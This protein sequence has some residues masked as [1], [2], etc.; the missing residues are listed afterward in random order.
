M[1]HNS[2]VIIMLCSHLSSDTDCKPLTPSEW[3]G[4]ADTLLQADLEPKALPDLSDS[5]FLDLKIGKEE[6][7]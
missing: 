4:L 7:V 2:E 5:E 1:N 6:T 3:S